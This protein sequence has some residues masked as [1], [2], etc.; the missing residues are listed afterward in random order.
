MTRTFAVTT[1]LL[2][3]TLLHTHHV[4]AA[5]TQ[6]MDPE[7]LFSSAMQ[8]RENGELFR[9]I[10]LFESILQSQPELN[11]ARLELAVSYHLTRRYED[12]RTQLNTVLNDSSTP[13]SVKLSVTA[14]LAQLNSDIK[15]ANKRSRSSFFLSAGMF[16]DSNI[17]LGPDNSRD[18]INLTPGAVKQ[19]SGG[20][21]G[22]FSYANR[23]RSSKPL[24]ING[25]AVDFEWLSQATAYAKAYGT[26][27]S[28]FNLSILSLSTGPA[29]ISSRNWRASLNFKLDKIYFGNDPYADSSGINPLFTYNIQNDLEITIENTTI[30]RDHSNTANKGLDGTLSSWDLNLAKFYNK[31]L[32]GVQL[33]VKYHDN[34]AANSQQHYRGAEIYLAG[35][36]PAW[37]NSRTYMTLSQRDYNYMAADGNISDDR[38]DTELNLQLG[39]SH[40]FR[41]GNLKSWT[42]NAQFNY[43]DNDSNVDLFEY[44]RNLVE[45]N[46]R[47]YFF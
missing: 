9:A 24:A 7:T 12:A 47:R 38:S 22:L 31:Q 43:T 26:G 14:Y 27:D 5:D 36:M 23:S 41:S 16:S 19:G 30:V 28:D 17:N 29:M 39:L 15:S 18:I 2:S 10:E 45:V 40:D 42:I 6:A 20:V 34:G 33:G 44:E 46:M 11:R 8:Y 1:L 4:A 32:I 25:R 21:R 3:S 37:K 35:Q 13:E